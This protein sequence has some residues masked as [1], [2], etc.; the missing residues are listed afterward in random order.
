MTWSSVTLPGLAVPIGVHGCLVT[1]WCME[2]SVPGGL[3]TGRLGGTKVH[4]LM[5]GLEPQIRDNTVANSRPPVCDRPRNSNRNRVAHWTDNSVVTFWNNA[6]N[7][8]RVGV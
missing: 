6:R 5:A 2:L 7:Q 3:G 8:S 4:P 1:C